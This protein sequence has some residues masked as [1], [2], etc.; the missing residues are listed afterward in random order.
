M[1]KN[2]KKWV[3]KNRPQMSQQVKVSNRSFKVT[4]IN[5]FK[6]INKNIDIHQRPGI[7]FKNQMKF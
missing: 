1:I 4:M 7:Y 5:M 3:S 2:Q 6:I